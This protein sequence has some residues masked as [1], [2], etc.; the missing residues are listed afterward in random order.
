MQK[1]KN[2]KMPI[3]FLAIIAAIGMLACGDDKTELAWTKRTG[4]NNF[5]VIDIKWVPQGAPD[6]SFATTL[7]NDGETT[8]YREISDDALWGQGEAWIL[9]YDGPA[10]IRFDDTGETSIKLSS[11]STNN[12]DIR[13]TPSKKK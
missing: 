7:Q 11:G 10:E 1:C 5:N 13:D 6:V 9:E 12:Y 3:L 4:N 8:E 2:A